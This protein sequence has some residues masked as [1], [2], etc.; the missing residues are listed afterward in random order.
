MEKKIIALVAVATLSLLVIAGIAAAQGMWKNKDSQQM[1]MQG[2]GMM[3]GS[4]MKGMIQHHAEME[5]LMEEGTFSDLVKLREKYD[6]NIMPWVENEADF[7][8]AKQIHEKMEKH[9]KENGFAE[10]HCP[11]MG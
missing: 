8:L 3:H 9:A 5:K 1:G 10:G 4:V 2:M 11:M 7:A 6:F